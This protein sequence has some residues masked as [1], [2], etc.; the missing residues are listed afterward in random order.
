MNRILLLLWKQVAGTKA[1]RISGED[2]AYGNPIVTPDGKWVIASKVDND[3]CPSQIIS[4]ASNL[5]TGREFRVNLEAADQFDPVVFLAAHN[6]VLLRRAKDEDDP[7]S[8][9]SAG[10]LQIT[11]K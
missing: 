2:G 3:W 10:P 6:K 8:K 4:S 7:P 5:Q 9:T 1:V 11:P